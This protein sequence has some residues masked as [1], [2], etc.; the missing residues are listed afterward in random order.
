MDKGMGGGVQRLRGPSRQGGG[1]VERIE[2]AGG[3]ADR[4]RGGV[5]A[6]CGAD[7]PK[8][9]LD[10][11]RG[12]RKQ[13]TWMRGLDVFTGHDCEHVVHLTRFNY[14]LDILLH[15]DRHH[16]GQHASHPTI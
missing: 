5:R 11:L 6:S 8:I 2:P 14:V 7:S 13:C 1:A 16:A 9:F 15:A 3:S 12:F 10:R 4:G